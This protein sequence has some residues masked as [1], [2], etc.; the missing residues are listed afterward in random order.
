MMRR[1]ATRE[2]GTRRRRWTTGV[3]IIAVALQA[4]A[5]GTDIAPEIDTE[6]RF[7]GTAQKPP[8]APPEPF[9]MSLFLRKLASSQ[10]GVGG[11]FDVGNGAVRGAVTGTLTGTLDDGTFSGRLIAAENRPGLARVL[12]PWQARGTGPVFGLLFVPSLMVMTSLQDIGC[13]VEQEYTGAV[14][15]TEIVWTPGRIIRGCP[16]NP[17]NFVIRATPILTLEAT[18]S[19][20]STSTI[21]TTSTTSTT[22]TTTTSV[23]TT[24]TTSTS[25]TSTTTTIE[26]TT[27]TT[28]TIRPLGQP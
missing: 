18:T 8:P 11:G 12:E 1:A 5:C 6:R 3:A 16:T 27:S 15:L 2:H 20:S 23:P 19:V 26:A 4:W 7:Q 24:S 9:D 13:V 22:S 25:T 17:L 21:P 10:H 28:T 14:T